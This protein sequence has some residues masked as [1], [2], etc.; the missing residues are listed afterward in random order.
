MFSF[1]DEYCEHKTQKQSQ[2]NTVYICTYLQLSVP[3]RPYTLVY[4]NKY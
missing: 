1:Q 4:Q 2:V 3:F